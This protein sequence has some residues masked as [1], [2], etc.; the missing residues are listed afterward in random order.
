M[1]LD[2]LRYPYIEL[3]KGA[4]KYKQG[5]DLSVNEIEHIKS[6]PNDRYQIAK[7][8]LILWKTLA[9]NAQELYELVPYLIP[10]ETAEEYY[11]HGVFLMIENQN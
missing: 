9:L 10:I 5:Y 3:C 2:K 6:M 11:Y 4:L 7:I 1:K 8:K